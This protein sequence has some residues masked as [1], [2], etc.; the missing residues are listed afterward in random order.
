MI[1]KNHD[2]FDILKE[3]YYILRNDSDDINQKMNQSKR[4]FDKLSKYHKRFAL[5]TS[6]YIL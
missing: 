2:D 1:S 4:W 5:I 3:F 6:D